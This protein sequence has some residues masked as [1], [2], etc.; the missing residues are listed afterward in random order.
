MFALPVKHQKTM[1]QL[2]SE[3]QNGAKM[4][5]GPFGIINRELFQLVSHL[6]NFPIIRNENIRKFIE[7]LFEFSRFR[8]GSTLS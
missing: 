4:V 1:L 2:I 6:E 5:F 7:F 3:K 8:I